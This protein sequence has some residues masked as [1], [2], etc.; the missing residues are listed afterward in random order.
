MPAAVAQRDQE[1][2]LDVELAAEPPAGRPVDRDGVD[3]VGERP[4]QLAR[5]RP[6]GQPPR[7]PKE[8]EDVVAAAVDARNLDRAG[9]L[10]DSVVGDHL[11]ESA[12]VTTAERVEDTPDVTKGVYFSSG[13]I[14]SP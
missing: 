9:Y 7:R 14:V 10:P 4:A 12:G 11:E 6:V 2:L 1:H 3:A 8:L 5:V 13:A